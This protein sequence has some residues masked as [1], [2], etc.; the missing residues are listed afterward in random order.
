MLDV[1][2]AQLLDQPDVLVPSRYIPIVGEIT[3]PENSFKHLQDVGTAGLFVYAPGLR[4]LIGR[5]GVSEDH[6]ESK[7]YWACCY[8]S[9][10]PVQDYD[11]VRNASG[12][13]LYD[14]AIK[15]TKDLAPYLTD[16]I[17]SSGP[18]HMMR[19]PV[20]FVEFFPTEGMRLSS[21]SITLLGDAIHTMIPFYLAGAN[22]A[23]RDA[24]DLARA[25]S[26]YPQNLSTA[27]QYYEEI[28]IPRAREMV[29]RSRAAGEWP[30]LNGIV[31]RPSAIRSA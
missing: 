1:V 29:L 21:S 23:I 6:S 11:W 13:E 16:I 12:E 25:L 3:L 19:S 18:H 15:L 17:R 20:Q 4:Y 5:L 14:R 30:D 10:N 7:Y 26:Q 24:C 9:N 22:T 31:K 2:R 27:L 8:Q 28:M